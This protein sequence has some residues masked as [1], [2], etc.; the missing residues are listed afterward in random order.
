MQTI[1]S[2]HWHHLPAQ[3]VLDLLEADADTGLDVFEI[4]HRRER[5]GPNVITRRKTQGPL[6]RLFLQFHQ[7]LIYILLAAVLITAI[8]REWVD[9]GVILGVVLVNRSEEHTSELQSH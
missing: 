2:K 6:V 5:F 1:L 7:P 8:L 9:S 3:E 4:V